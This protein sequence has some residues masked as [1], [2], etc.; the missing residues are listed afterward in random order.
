MCLLGLGIDGE[1]RMS[2]EGRVGGN[3]GPCPSNKGE[4]RGPKEAIP[5][6][7]NRWMGGNSFPAKKAQSNNY[8]ISFFLPMDGQLFNV[9]RREFDYER[10]EDV[11]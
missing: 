5:V 2:V 10:L 8:H 7:G 1:T 4:F 3:E 11:G 9:Q 6:R